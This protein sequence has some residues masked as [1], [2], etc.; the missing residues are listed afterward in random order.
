MYK[1]HQPEQFHTNC[2]SIFVKYSPLSILVTTFW[3]FLMFYQFFFSPQVK[4]SVIITNKHGIYE[5]PLELPYDLRLRILGNYEISG[6]SKNDNLV[7]SLP[8]KMKLLPILAENSLKIKMDFSHSVLF[9]MK[10]RVYLTYFVRDCICLL[11]KGKHRYHNC[12]KKHPYNNCVC[13]YV[14]G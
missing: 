1:T 11:W 7:L 10:T 5:L 8:P 12:H 9:H 2:C 4:R 6:K 14:C 13:M 3:D